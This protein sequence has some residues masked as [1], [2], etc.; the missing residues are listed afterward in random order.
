MFIGTARIGYRIWQVYWGEACLVLALIAL[1][2][3]SDVLFVLDAL[4]AQFGP[5]LADPARA[6]LGI[7]RVVCGNI[8]S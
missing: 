2:A 3:A 4:C 1:S 8:V 6:I 5:L 7:V